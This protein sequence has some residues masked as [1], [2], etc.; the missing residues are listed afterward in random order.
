MIWQIVIICLHDSNRTDRMTITRLLCQCYYLMKAK[1]RKGN[2]P[3]EPKTEKER[4][5]RLE[6]RK[7]QNTHSHT[8]TS[9]VIAFE[10]DRTRHFKTT[11]KFH[12]NSA[13][14]MQKYS[15]CHTIRCRLLVVLECLTN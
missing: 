11:Q 6:H 5:F 4:I 14:E 3:N 12:P 15:F 7:P 1:S 10:C 8:H 2:W 9:I 13:N